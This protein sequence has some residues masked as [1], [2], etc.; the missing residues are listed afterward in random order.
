MSYTHIESERDVG[1]L[2]ADLNSAKRITLDC[3][4]AGFHRYSDRICLVQLSTADATYVVD[5]L[6]FDPSDVLRD[7]VEDPLRE[8]V[9]H[10]ADF[11]LRLLHRDLGLDL[12]G[13]FDTQIAASLL[14]LETLGL[15][16]LLGERFGVKLSKKY[17]R[18]DWAERP[19]TEGMLDYAASDTIYL[20]A[21]RDQLVEELTEAGRL[22]WVEEECRAL[23]QSATMRKD[24]AAPRDPVTRVKG[25]RHL[26]PRQVTA[27]REA[28]SWRDEVARERDKAPFRIVGDGPLIDAVALHPRRA[29]ELTSI[30]GFPRGLAKGEGRQLVSRLHA[31]VAI[32][33]EELVPY[34]R[35]GG[36]GPGHPPPEVEELAEKLKAARNKAADE[37]GLA[38]GTLLSNAVLVEVARAAPEDTE[39]L[40]AVGG[41]RR[42]RM[43]VLGDDLLAVIRKR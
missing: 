28:L 13:L 38:R 22:A 11:D 6:A 42:W 15:A 31:V 1:A 41:M 18:A 37:L 29:E 34:P 25:A 36:G 30:K 7:V 24:G 39:A 5:P 14:G 8:V 43:H 16:S 26:S 17:Q 9:M 35:K 10:G 33:E 23:E 27:L 12:H 4:A 20:L 19:L 3:E 32:P 21:L 2:I 40:A